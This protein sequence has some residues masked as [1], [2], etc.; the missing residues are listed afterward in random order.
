[1]LNLKSHNTKHPGNLGHCEKT[2]PKNNMTRGRRIP[3]Q[4]SRKYFQQN[5]KK[6]KNVHRRT[7][8]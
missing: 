3:V 5:V 2:K 6:T 7:I 1:M 4:R 8:F